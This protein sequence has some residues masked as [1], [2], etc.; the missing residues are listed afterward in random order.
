MNIAIITARGG[1]K[2]LKRKNILDFN[3]KPL[4]AWTIEAALNSK[5]IDE[6]FVTT[7]DDEIAE[8]S[9][10]HGAKVIPRPI[11]LAGDFVTSEDVLVHALSELEETFE[12]IDILAL[13]QPTSPLRSST[14]I[15]LAIQEYIKSSADCVISVFKP[16]HSAAKAYK[17]NENG[18]IS[19][20][21][22]ESAPYEPRQNLPQTFQ[23][24]GAIYVFNSE[25]FKS[26]GKIPRENVYPFEMSEETSID[27]DDIDDFR[28]A[29]EQMRN[30]NEA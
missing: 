14:E 28:K 17:L 23:P 5:R 21:F 25:K 15:D 24:N 4:I 6:C 9:I 27:I 19:G 10:M 3:G 12:H 13:L 11:N 7:E 26:A 8:V 18:S 1:S 29:E 22:D 20:L 30:S 16:K 2:G